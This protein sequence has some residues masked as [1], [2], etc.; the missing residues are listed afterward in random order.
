MLISSNDVEQSRKF[1][2]KLKITSRRLV[3]PNYKLYQN[4][5][6]VSPQVMQTSRESLKKIEN[7][8]AKDDKKSSRR[9]IQF[10]NNKKYEKSFLTD[11]III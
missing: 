11:M 5:F 6:I 4:E 9:M 1:L 2:K 8:M 10:E 3:D 7:M